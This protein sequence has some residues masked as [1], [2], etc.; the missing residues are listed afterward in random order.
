MELE[1]IITIITLAVGLIGAIA[2]LIPSLIKLF[3]SLKEIAQNKDWGKIKAIIKA[4]IVKAEASGKAGA[5]KKQ[6][7]I[8]ATIA[9][10]KEIG[11]EVDEALVEQISEY[12][13]K[14]IS[15]VNEMATKPAVKSKKAK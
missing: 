7:V 4:A 14:T 13:E 2:A 1:S 11:V 3:K 5:D 8:D 15:F 10:C 12:I 9:G 6:M